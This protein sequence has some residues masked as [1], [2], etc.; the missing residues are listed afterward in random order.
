MTYNKVSTDP[1]TFWIPH[2]TLIL[3]KC[4][5]MSFRSY[6]CLSHRSNRSMLFHSTSL[7][8][9]V[10]HIITLTLSLYHY[11][12]NRPTTLSTKIMDLKFRQHLIRC[13]RNNWCD[14]WPHWGYLSSCRCCRPP[15]H[16]CKYI[17]YI[18]RCCL[19]HYSCCFWFEKCNIHDTS[20]TSVRT[21][22]NTDFA[23]LSHNNLRWSVCLYP[24]YSIDI[25]INIR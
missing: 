18:C 2:S 17:L 5:R 6:R 25:D 3:W 11:S 16:L 12:I 1:I 20:G 14:L 23:I 13:R 19:K 7:L 22:A 15:C 10:S 9:S 21:V 24:I 8:S 4:S